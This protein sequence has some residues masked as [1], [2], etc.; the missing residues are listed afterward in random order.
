[1]T[2]LELRHLTEESLDDMIEVLAKARANDPHNRRL[3]YEEARE[4]TFLDPDFDPK[5]S[6]LA[7]LDGMPIGFCSVLVM[8]NRIDAGMDDAYLEVDLL[9]E[10]RE[11]DAE[12]TLLEKGLDYIRSRSV[13]KVLCRSLADDDWTRNFLV[14]NSFKE[15]YRVYT[16]CRSGK[17]EIEGVYLPEGFRL[18]RRP[19]GDL[20]D[21]ETIAVVEVLNDSFQDHMNFAPELPERFINFRDCSEDP[22]AITLAF[23]D[24]ETVGL[25]LSEESAGFN[26]EKGVKAGWVDVVGV[27]P[28]YRRIG[29]GKALLA[30]G[31]N[32]IL[33]TG[34]DKV[35][36]GA[37]AVNEKALDLYRSFGF[38]KERESI[39]YSRVVEKL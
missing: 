33:S 1:V 30:D 22:R 7:S 38:S 29:L 18:E 3:T 20:T 16:L 37:Y 11:N 5:G 39:W 12:Q 32:W 15:D 13:G 31:V 8:G 17:K 14:S 9:P 26:R 21:E 23:K 34:M 6:W 2:G 25:C 19:F 10:H 24:D 4:Y 35:Y 27:R 28:A 36:L